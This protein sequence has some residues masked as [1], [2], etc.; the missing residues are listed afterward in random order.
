MRLGGIGGLFLATIIGFQSAIPAPATRFLLDG[1]GRANT[2]GW[3]SLG[4]LAISP[5]GSRVA[6]IATDDPG[7]IGPG[8]QN[9]DI[10]IKPV[11][12]GPATR[13]RIDDQPIGIH[14]LAFSPDGQSLVF[15]AANGLQRVPVTG[16]P[17]TVIC[18]AQ[19]VNGISWGIDS[20]IVFGMGPSVMRVAATGGTPETLIT[21]Q[22]ALMTANPEV[23]ADSGAVLF[24]QYPI[25]FGSRPQIV[26]QQPRTAARVVVANE[27]MDA[28]YLADTRQIVYELDGRLFAVPFDARELRVTG[29]AIQILDGVTETRYSTRGYFGFSATGAL[30]YATGRHGW[31]DGILVTRDGTRRTVARFTGTTASARAS[32]DGTRVA[33]DGE[34]HIWTATLGDVASVRQLTNGEMDHAPV[35]SPDGG[36]IVY[37]RYDGDERVDSIYT[38]RADGPGEAQRLVHRA[39]QPESWSAGHIWFFRHIG[40][41]YSLWKYSTDDRSSRLFRYLTWHS[42]TSAISPNGEWIA[43]A[44]GPQRD[45]T[46]YSPGHLYVESVIKPGRRFA[47]P[48][49]GGRPAWS[50]DGR[51]LFFDDG[52]RLFVVA[53]RNSGGV[54]TFGDARPVPVD[55]FLQRGGD[56]GYDARKRGYDVMPDGKSLLMIFPAP[57]ELG[58]VPNW[59]R[60]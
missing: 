35:W 36:Q 23:L 24:T 50:P 28:R 10:W 9:H 4:G 12:G 8:R 55:G 60:R 19:R 31:R 49:S 33:F 46:P 38:M 2:R 43:Y 15:W 59:R 47:L 40:N 18:G 14:D 11:D 54:V 56:V 16:G 20:R 58:I 26:V 32:P 44:D 29:S 41:S 17:T 1:T 21:A 13:L 57:V 45:A 34:G 37:A 39:F 52:G 51:E 5:E 30:M 48:Q 3:G 25:G 42:P 6:Y 53:V 7:G 27:G 22:N